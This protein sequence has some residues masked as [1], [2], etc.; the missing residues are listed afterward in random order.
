[1][2]VRQEFQHVLQIQSPFAPKS[3]GQSSSAMAL[4]NF[5]ATCGR[6][7]RPVIAKLQ[8]QVCFPVFNS[9]PRVWARLLST[10]N[11]GCRSVDQ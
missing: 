4:P 10:L 3:A 1:M 6:S 7:W 8:P 2:E 11:E 9:R 5:N